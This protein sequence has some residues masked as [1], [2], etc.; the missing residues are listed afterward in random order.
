M[1]VLEEGPYR[2]EHT[3]VCIGKFD[4]LHSGHRM[5]L[6]AVRACGAETKV[7]FTFSF[8]NVP[9]IYSKE[10]K[11]YLAETLGVDVYIDC[12]FD[13]RISRMSPQAFLS[14]VI[15]GECGAGTVAVGE[16]FRFGY[17]RSGDVEFLERESRAKGFL[18]KVCPQKKISGEAVSSTRIRERLREG[19]MDMVNRLLG[20]PYFIYG[21]VRHGNRIGSTRLHMP[22]AN[23][24]PP[25]EKILPP[26]GAYASRVRFD[27]RDYTGITNI[28]VRPTVSGENRV[29]AET[30]IIGLDADLYGVCL[31]VE[32]HAFLR[33][34]RKFPGLD[35]LRRQL[36]EDRRQAV[37]LLGES[38]NATVKE[39]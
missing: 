16:D 21:D 6:E 8:P 10:E 31:R 7:L 12:P 2:L 14:D 26:F 24:I 38:T 3:A 11:R 23:Q 39:E 27:G 20:Q 32:L 36:G 28:G 13:E 33:R 5:L 4:G 1:I 18:L 15:L 37:R 22:T 25:P 30:H 9:S 29:G 17:K 34:E 35:A 19:D